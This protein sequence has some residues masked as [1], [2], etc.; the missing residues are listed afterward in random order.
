[1]FAIQNLRKCNKS[2]K[3]ISQM[4]IGILTYHRALNY[5]AFLQAYALKEFMESLGNSVEFINYES[6][7]HA[8]EY[9]FFNKSLL[10]RMSVRGQLSYIIKRLIGL[11]RMIKR[12]HRMRKLQKEF[13]GVRKKPFRTLDQIE[14]KEYDCIIYGSDQIWRSSTAN[15]NGQ[16]DDIYWGKGFR[17]VKKVAYAPSMGVLHS[18]SKTKCYISKMIKNFNKISCR[19][20]DLKILVESV[21]TSE[22]TQVVDPVFLFNQDF[23]ESHCIK[24]YRV[25]PKTYILVYNLMQS[26]EVIQVANIYAKKYNCEIIEITG[27]VQPLKMGKN[28]IQ[29]A[30]AFEF[31][32]LIRD[33]K[34]IITSSFHAV[35]F[36][37]IFRKDFYAIGMGKNAGRVSTLLNL[38]GIPNRLISDINEVSFDHVIYHENSLQEAIKSSKDFLCNAI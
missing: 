20:A 4:K 16:F 1:M 6:I 37:I 9:V 29:T 23:W 18:D 14:N 11:P 38:A 36:S 30:N 33:A 13:L 27:S 17:G 24:S 35:A 2:N 15:P 8:R 5:G 10:K 21:S 31:I 25:L 28:F 32:S 22:V 7:E 34:I 26:S 12:V 19:E 3:I